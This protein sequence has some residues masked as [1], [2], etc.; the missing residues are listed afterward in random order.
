MQGQDIEKAQALCPLGA[1][2]DLDGFFETP[3][4]TRPEAVLP[5]VA[6]L[7]AQ[8]EDDGFGPHVPLGPAGP[9]RRGERRDRRRRPTRATSR[10]TL[11]WRPP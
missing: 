3:W 7:D 4:E 2:S 8:D 6:D 5:E 10:R 9:S 1:P 11:S